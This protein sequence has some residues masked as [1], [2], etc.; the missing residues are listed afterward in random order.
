ML[1]ITNREI[2]IKPQWKLSHIFCD[3]QY[4]EEDNSKF[5]KDMEK[6]EHLYTIVGNVKCFNLYRKQYGVSSEN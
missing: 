3:G 1:N 4:E 5:R 2:Q 6:L